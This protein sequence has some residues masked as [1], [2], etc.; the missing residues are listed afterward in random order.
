MGP[1]AILIPSL[2]LLATVLVGLFWGKAVVIRLAMGLLCAAALLRA[3]W[4]MDQTREA[5]TGEALHL[6][7]A[8]GSLM[9]IWL[10]LRWDLPAQPE[11]EVVEQEKP[12]EPPAKPP[13]EQRTDPASP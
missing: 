2:V 6:L 7:V 13:T 4:S 12:Y 3:V 5:T 1:I 10:T 11:E 9:A 8:L